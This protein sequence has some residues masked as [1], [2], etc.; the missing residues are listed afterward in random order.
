MDSC[1]SRGEFRS[2][3]VATCHQRRLDLMMDDRFELTH[4]HDGP[5]TPTARTYASM[6]DLI[7]YR[8]LAEQRL[9]FLEGQVAFLLAEREERAR[10]TLKIGDQRDEARFYRAWAEQR[11]TVLEAANTFFDQDAHWQRPHSTS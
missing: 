4:H 5:P 6:D 11:I 9:S 3:L 10:L 2:R 7:A 8:K 1:A